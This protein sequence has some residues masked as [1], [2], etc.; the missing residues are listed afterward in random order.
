LD[1]YTLAHGIPGWPGSSVA[2]DRA[3]ARDDD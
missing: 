2:E 3:V 1:Q